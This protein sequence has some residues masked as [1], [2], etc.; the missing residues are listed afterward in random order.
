MQRGGDG[1]RNFK[2]RDLEVL[3]EKVLFQKI[4]ERGGGSKCKGLKMEACLSF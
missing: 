1:F 3:I 4:S 2:S